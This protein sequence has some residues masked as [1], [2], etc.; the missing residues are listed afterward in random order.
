MTYIKY[1]NKERESQVVFNPMPA[2]AI[3]GPPHSGKSV[4]AY[5]LTRALR[6]RE[7]LHYLL[8][9]YPPDYEGDWFYEGERE[10]VRLV[11]LK[12]ARSDAWLPLLRRDIAN[13]HLPLIVDMGGLPTTEQEKILDD[14]THAIL[15][16][17]DEESRREWAARFADHGLVLLADLHSD[18]HGENSLTATRPLLTGTLAGL[19][20]G[21][22]AGGPAFDA[23]LDRL[24]ELFSTVPG[25]L[26]AR[27]LAA[28]PAE[29]AV[30]VERMARHLNADPLNWQPAELSKVLDYL[31]GGV[32]LALYGRGPNWLYAAVA[33]HAL[34]APFY[35]FDVRLGWVPTPTIDV[36]VPPAGGPITVSQRSRPDATLLS[37]TLLDAYLDINQATEL[38]VPACQAGGVIIGGKL[39]HWL[40]A[41][42]ARH[43]DADWVAVQYPQMRCAIVVR[44]RSR[45]PSVGDTISAPPTITHVNEARGG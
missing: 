20:R 36:G 37:F 44:S 18:L 35:L 9:A 26:Q 45:S 12:G 2:V 25:N 33:A 40:W 34:P 5:S 28:A 4:L 43:Y 15:L 14:C 38:R 29:L 13:R 11:R 19:E 3:G 39:P 31:P 17:P 7:V 8:R 42:L 21:Q 6:K 1:N 10:W 16:T 22:M 23:L 32:P 30:D 27:H 41:A 24:A